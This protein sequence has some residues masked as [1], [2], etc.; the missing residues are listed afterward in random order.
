MCCVENDRVE[1]DSALLV[2]P[3]Q[4][5][6]TLQRPQ[7]V[8]GVCMFQESDRVAGH[9]RCVRHRREV[10]CRGSSLWA[11]G[12]CRCVLRRH[13]VRCG[14]SSLCWVCACFRRVMEVTVLRDFGVGTAG[15]LYHASV[16]GCDRGPCNGVVMG[17]S[18][19]GRTRV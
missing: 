9:C 4:A 3:I 17:L 14:G 6:G 13:R 18:V 12:H 11:T 16:E 1:S 10:R 7:P 5:L 19:T 15:S 2:C 8:L